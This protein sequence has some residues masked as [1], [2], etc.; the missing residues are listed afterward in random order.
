MPFASGQTFASFIKDD[1]AA[2]FAA[3]EKT[4]LH[5]G[6]GAVLQ[7]FHLH[8]GIVAEASEVVFDA[9]AGPREG[10]LADRENFPVHKQHIRDWGKFRSAPCIRVGLV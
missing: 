10:R 4:L 7:V 9:L 3:F 1:P 2:A 6:P 8:F 5:L